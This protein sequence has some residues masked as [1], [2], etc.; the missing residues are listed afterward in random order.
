VDELHAH[1]NRQLYDVLASSMIAR[2]QPLFI[3]TT[4]AGH[5][6]NHICYE[7]Y[8][9]AKRVADGDAT[10]PSYL[11]VIFEADEKD[12][13]HDPKVWRRV[14]PNYGVSIEDRLYRDEYRHACEIPG[15]EN[16]FKRLHL[17]LWTEQDSRWL[18]MDIWR[19]CPG[20]PRDDAW[21][22]GLRGRE[23][24]VGID[25]SSVRDLTAMVGVI[26]DEK[27]ESFDIICKCWVPA[28][29]A[30]IRARRDKVDYLKWA[31]EGH[32]E[33]TAGAST[34][35]GAIMV[36]LDKWSDRFRIMDVAVDPWNGERLILELEDLGYQSLKHQQ[37]YASMSGPSKALERRLLQRQLRHGGH[38]VLEWC[39]K[40]TSILTDP[41][42]NIKPAKDKSADRIDLVVALVMALGRAI[43]PPTGTSVYD[44]RGGG[45]Q[46][47]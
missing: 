28:D 31:R 33:L 19:E 3:V 34:D 27:R 41:A 9:Y 43:L 30:A 10:D 29:T 25:L 36:G 12:D 8:V 23:C 11:P 18:P 37:G 4:T 47:I 20:P 1:E 42:G 7:Q 40:N 44:R 32:I 39:A 16:T 26:P 24:Y 22:E 2:K 5:D 35:Q 6:R 17:N 15:Y 38:P 21:W 13:W 46:S 14:N 45:F